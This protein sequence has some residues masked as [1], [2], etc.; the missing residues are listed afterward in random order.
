[1]RGRKQYAFPI[2]ENIIVMRQTHI[3]YTKAQVYDET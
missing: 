3:H 1:V 2:N